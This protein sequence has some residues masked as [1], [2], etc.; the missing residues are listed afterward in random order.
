[1]SE[2][3]N[4]TCQLQIDIQTIFNVLT[5]NL[6]VHVFHEWAGFSYIFMSAKHK[7]KY[8]KKK[9]IPPHG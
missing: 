2:R 8:L 9:K 7:G 1:M 6:Q 4:Q 5:F 3:C